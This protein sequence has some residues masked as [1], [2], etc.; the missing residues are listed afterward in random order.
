LTF[1]FVGFFAHSV[2]AAGLVPCGDGNDPNGTGTNQ[3]C[4]LCH[5]VLGIQGL[6]DYGFKIFVGL[7]LLMMVVGGVLYI[8]S[9]GDHGLIDMA[10]GILKNTLYGFAFVLLAWLLVNYTIFLLGAN[11]GI[12]VAGRTWDNFTCSTAR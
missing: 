11:V 9:A 6:I 1:I 4:T 2:S 8:V 12:D 10:K 7:A 3:Q 5:L